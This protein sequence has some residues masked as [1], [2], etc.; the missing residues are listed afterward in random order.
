MREN[1]IKANSGREALEYLLKTDIAVVLMD[2]SMPDIDGFQLADMIRE[3]PRFQKTAII[4]ISAVHLSDVDRLKG[5]ERGA[6]DYISVPVIP[7]LLRAK[8]S[9]FAEL[10]RKTQQLETLNRELEQRVA[11][12][13]EELR[14]S[15]SQFRSLAN[16]I[17]QLAWMAHPDGSIFWYNQRWY[18]FTGTTFDDVQRLGLENVLHPDH[19][20]AAR[21]Q[22]STLPG[23]RRTMGRY[24]PFATAKT[25]TIA[26]FFPAPCPSVM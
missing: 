11:E 1:L 2:V 14:E 13:T 15:E 6:V 4:F 9:V 22:I 20:D 5:Y 24:F 3:H 8:V 16:S 12:R 23:H 10:Y 25:A 26:G 21:S 19:L 18:D 7:E 17:P